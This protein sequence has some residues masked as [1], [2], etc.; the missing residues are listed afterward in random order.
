VRGNVEWSE[1]MLMD[2]LA[3]VE[4]P[5][6][7]EQ[8]RRSWWPEVE[9]MVVLAAVEGWK[10]QSDKGEINERVRGRVSPT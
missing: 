3:G 5:M 2:L 4:W 8:H 9:L 7:V 6:E 10:Q 1:G